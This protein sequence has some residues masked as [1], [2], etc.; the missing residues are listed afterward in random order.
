MV[1]T[2][3]VLASQSVARKSLLTNAGLI[4]DQISA[5]IDERAVEEPLIHSGLS[6]ADIAEVLARA[7]AV[8]VSERHPG[9]LVIGA[10]QTMSFTI[11]G[12]E[13]RFNKPE[14]MDAARRQLL[15]LR[16]KKHNLHAAICVVKNGEVLWS[17]LSDAHLTMRDFSPEFVGHY[18]AEVGDAALTS[19]G[20]YQLEGRG[21]QLFDKIEGDY[22]TILGLP[23]LPLLTFLRNY[24][25]LDA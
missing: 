4:F 24:G 9:A 19:V 6:A 10:D 14:N 17:H 8:D 3:L 20:A 13:Q 25:L 23:L 7:K 11:D 5:D 2:R 12:E 16:G 18:L 22:F 1:E 21:A 15:T